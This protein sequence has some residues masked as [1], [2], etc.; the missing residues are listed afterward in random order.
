MPISNGD[1][2]DMARGEAK[3][4]IREGGEPVGAVIVTDGEILGRGRNRLHQ[5]SDPTAHEEM[6]AYRNTARKLRTDHGAN[7]L[8][9]RLFGASVFTTAMPCEMCKG[10]ILRFRA[11]RVV[12]AETAT[13]RPA[14]TQSLMESHGVTVDLLDDAQTITMIRQYLDVH[15]DRRAAFE[16]GDNRPVL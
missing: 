12:V 6:E 8:E 7:G 9:E 5:D 2:M 13:Y 14:G 1:A 15:P 10:T 16:Q 3:A 11:A 4:G